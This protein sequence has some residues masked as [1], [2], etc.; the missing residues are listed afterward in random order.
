MENTR[1]AA[2]LDLLRQRLTA[3]AP[4]V[5]ALSGGLDSRSLAHLAWSW[6]LDFR[7][8]H[9]SGPHISQAETTQARAW[10]AAQGK[11][12]EILQV[13]PL[14]HEG[15]CANEQ[16]RCYHC[17]KEMFQTLLEHA[18]GQ[19][20]L[21]VMEG[22]QA[23]DLEIFR[24]GRQA[25]AE[26]GVHSPLAEAGLNKPELR[27]VARA[28][29]LSNPGQAA[30]PC[31]L[32]RLE[33]GLRPTAELLKR[34]AAGE[35]EL[36][37]LGLCDFRLRLHLDGRAV[38]QVSLTEAGLAERLSRATGEILARHGFGHADLLVTGSVSGY[39]D[40]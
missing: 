19:G 17:K 12:L 6:D 38:L 18:S 16:D 33:Y 13:D 28:T 34:L 23:S 24:P 21:S 11:E 37:A 9:L 1:L 3:L 36:S 8:V 7:A 10:C 4:G 5:L 31:L 14:A 39:F 40:T 15:V 22:S 26:L 30:R 35:G 32:T 27:A 25:L 29:G 2:K 20:L